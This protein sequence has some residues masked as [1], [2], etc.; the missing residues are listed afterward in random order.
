M[1]VEAQSEGTSTL[2][3]MDDQEIPTTIK[4]KTTYELMDAALE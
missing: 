3:Q 1:T 2:T 4:S